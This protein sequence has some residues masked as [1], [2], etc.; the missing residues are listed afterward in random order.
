MNI[1]FGKGYISNFRRYIKI[2]FFVSSVI[3]L[4]LFVF[5]IGQY[6]FPHLT[7]AVQLYIEA[8]LFLAVVT[9]ILGLSLLTKT[10]N[11][12]ITAMQDF[13]LKL[14]VLF[15]NTKQFRGTVDPDIL[16]ENIIKNAVDLSY[17]EAGSLLLLDTADILRIKVAVGHFKEDIKGGF[18]KKGE[19][20]LGL[21]AETGEPV[22]INDV[23]KDKRYKMA[24]DNE[25][26]IYKKSLICVP[27]IYSHQIIGVIEV[28]NKME[29]IFTEED[30]KL[31]FA[32]ADQAAISI[33][34]SRLIENQHNDIMQMVETLIEAQN[35]FIPDKCGHPQ[36]VASYSDLIGKKMGLSKAELKNLHYAA[37]LH[38][39]G[40]I[41]IAQL[42]TCKKEPWD[43][44]SYLKHP[45]LGY[46]M[47]KPI[48]LLKD[49]AE[50]ILCHHERFDGT[51][52][53]GKKENQ[54]PFGAR[55][56]FVAETFDVLTSKDSYREQVDYSSAITEIE[57]NSGTQ[58][59]PEVVK[60][61]KS[62]IKDT[63]LVIEYSE[64]WKEYKEKSC[65]SQQ[66]HLP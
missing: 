11:T 1:S 41:K 40:F 43:K 48:S 39:V 17:A 58:F 29:G 2:S 5:L 20:V 24:L 6:A 50:L 37:L 28:L 21:V 36:R 60:A 44:E 34:Q 27:L 42:K 55:I 14:S 25:T 52:Y 15:E 4:G 35:M 64:W 46:E 63:D 30:E 53:L 56:L 51:G 13:H 18:V 57:A 8:V 22:I 16:L 19:G 33:M 32:L 62:S 66:I 7:F 23:I 61:L 10:V 65:K 9:A 49:A 12:S 3:P 38:D 26:G 45:Q 47:I 59:D 31:L 54:I